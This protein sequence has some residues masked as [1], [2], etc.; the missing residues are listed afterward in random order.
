MTRTIFAALA[1]AAANDDGLGGASPH[2]Q[3]AIREMRTA[4][5]FRVAKFTDCSELAAAGAF[6]REDR[7]GLPP[8]SALIFD[9]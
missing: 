1:W 4:S 7:P 2:R 5:N 6:R 3:C 8:I 9:P